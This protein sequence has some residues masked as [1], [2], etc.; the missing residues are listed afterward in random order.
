MANFYI[1]Y[2]NVKS[3]GVDGIETL[4]KG[5]KVFLFYSDQAD[6][7]KFETVI[8]LNST[9]AEVQLIRADNGTRNSLDFQLIAHLFNGI[10]HKTDT[11]IVTNDNGFDAAVK[12]GHRLGYPALHRISSL[13]VYVDKMTKS[14]SSDK[15]E[16]S[17]EDRKKLPLAKPLLLSDPDTKKKEPN[18]DVKEAVREAEREQQPKAQ[19]Q[20][21]SA[22]LPLPETAAES[23]VKAAPSEPA[24]EASQETAQDK[25][26]GCGSNHHRGRGRTRGTNKPQAGQAEAKTENKPEAK[27]EVKAEAETEVKAEEKP[28]R[29]RRP[30]RRRKTTLPQ[31]AG[32]A[33]SPAA[34][35]TETAKTELV[36]AEPVK[37]EPEKSE[38]V[39][40]EVIKAEPV[41]AEPEKAEA[42]KA[43]AVSAPEPVQTK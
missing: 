19:T 41:K 15:Q 7:I 20:E 17:A 2:E 1:D 10:R 28:R 13:S 40:T 3:K 4:K 34:A 23:V 29:G 43:E 31:A 5:D 30:G 16:T 25:N 24:K 12:M 18:A 6:S 14:V 35:G 38:T 9:R 22:V 11:Y 33:D 26:K 42:V 27:T 8:R 39:K 32:T 37:A 21:A 36:K